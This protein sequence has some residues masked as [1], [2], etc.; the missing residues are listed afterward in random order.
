MADCGVQHMIVGYAEN[1]DGDVY[2]AGKF[3]IHAE[4]G[5]MLVKKGNN[6]EVLSEREQTKNWIGVGKI[7]THDEDV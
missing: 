2:Q 7:L 6:E 5:G 1:H 4:A 3:M